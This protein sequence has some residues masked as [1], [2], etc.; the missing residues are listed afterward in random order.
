M[1]AD[2]LAEYLSIQGLGVLGQE[3]FWRQLPES[4]DNALCLYDET[5]IVLTESQ[6]YDSDV[7]GSQVIVRGSDAYARQ[8]AIEIHREMTALGIDQA[9]PGDIELM[10]THIVSVP[11]FIGN[12]EKGRALY[13]AH[14]MHYCH[15]GGNAQRTLK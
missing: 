1:I 5:G 14:Y 13:S 8:K 15:V 10:S 12:D 2:A 11:A 7:F 6:D 4:P 9:V 3:V